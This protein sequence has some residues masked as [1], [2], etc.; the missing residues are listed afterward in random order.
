MLAPV[1]NRGYSPQCVESQREGAED[2]AFGP[3]LCLRS[4]GQIFVGDEVGVIGRV[5]LSAGFVA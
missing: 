2:G 1:G 4:E 5:G 3:V